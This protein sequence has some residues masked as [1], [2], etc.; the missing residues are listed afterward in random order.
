MWLIDLLHKI[1]NI[2]WGTIIGSTITLLGTWLQGRNNLKMLLHK[3]DHDRKNAKEQRNFD[4]RKNEYLS[5]LS[6]IAEL[7]N[8]LTDFTNPGYKHDE[9]G[10]KIQITLKELLSLDI[11]ADVKTLE[12]IHKFQHYYFQ[13][14]VELMNLKIPLEMLVSD[15]RIAQNWHKFFSDKISETIDRL[16]QNPYKDPTDNQNF[17]EFLNSQY[18][19]YCKER[20]KYS[21]D[22]NKLGK[23]I[24]NMNLDLKRRIVERLATIQLHITEFIQYARKDL[25]LPMLAVDENSIQ[26]FYKSLNETLDS[27]FRNTMKLT[28]GDERQIEDASEKA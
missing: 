21:F 4:L 2:I 13:C 23:Q 12:P 27:T 26:T 22:L 28:Q 1:P 9:F 17:A 20:D 25:D 3:E 14:A 15:E 10:K 5:A 16:K 11:V 24:L 8:L 18:V 6:S 7:N 19:E